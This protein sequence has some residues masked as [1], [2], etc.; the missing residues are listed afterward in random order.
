MYT[1]THSGGSIDTQG[2]FEGLGSLIGVP[3]HFK[4]GAA[5]GSNLQTEAAAS[6]RGN[7]KDIMEANS[8]PNTGSNK[9]TVVILF[10]MIA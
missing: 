10:A 1:L 8:E 5:S 7:D 2:A 9:L 3:S 6:T 4:A